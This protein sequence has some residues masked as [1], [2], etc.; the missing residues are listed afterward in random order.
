MRATS[1][2][3]TKARF[4]EPCDGLEGTEYGVAN[5]RRLCVIY[6][7]SKDQPVEYI[8]YVKAFGKELKMREGAVVTL[9]DFMKEYL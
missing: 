6:R 2:H 4:P 1:T 3:P 8:R 9:A 5:G 7:A